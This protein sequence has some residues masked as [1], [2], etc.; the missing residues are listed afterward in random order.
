MINVFNCPDVLFKVRDKRYGIKY[1]CKCYL[2]NSHLQDSVELSKENKVRNLTQGE[3]DQISG[4][5]A[6]VV[7]VGAVAGAVSSGVAAYL[8]GASAGGVAVAS[9]LGGVA[10]VYG[11]VATTISG[12]GRIVYGVNAAAIK[13]TS[14]LPGLNNSP[15][16]DAQ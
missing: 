2:Y 16:L 3:V 13:G 9:I 11:A 1:Y 12:V 7:V 6:P 4:G 14:M 15:Q 10:G 8:G 5:I